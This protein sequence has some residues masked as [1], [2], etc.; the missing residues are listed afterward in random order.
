MTASLH[1][2]TSLNGHTKEKKTDAFVIS[3]YTKGPSALELADQCADD[4]LH[5]AICMLCGKYQLGIQGMGETNKNG[6]RRIILIVSGSTESALEIVNKVLEMDCVY[7]ANF[8]RLHRPLG[9][10]PHVIVKLRIL[11][12]RLEHFRRELEC[13]SVTNILIKGSTG[14]PERY[15][16]VTLLTSKSESLKAIQKYSSNKQLK[17]MDIAWHVTPG[18]RAIES[19]ML[20]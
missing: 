17:S 7:F 6:K 4:Q 16:I 14:H 15:A 1:A 11:H 18:A 19:A 2:G 5:Q 8:Q 20:C 9:A 10:A 12:R 3:I 13:G